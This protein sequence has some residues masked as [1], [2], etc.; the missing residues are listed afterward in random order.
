MN[1]EIIQDVKDSWLAHW[2]MIKQRKAFCRRKRCWLI[3]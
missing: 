2:T 1:E 3:S